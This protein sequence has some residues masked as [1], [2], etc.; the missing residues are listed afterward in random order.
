MPG[1]PT[2][3]VA[4]QYQTKHNEAWHSET[5]TVRA[6]TIWSAAKK[7]MAKIQPVGIEVWT[8]KVEVERLGREEQSE[9]WRS[10]E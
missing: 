10:R 9:W 8:I 3:R 4:L 6:R 2:Y 1:E 5:V 7:G